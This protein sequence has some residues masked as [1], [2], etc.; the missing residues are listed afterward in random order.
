MKRLVA[1]KKQDGS[2]AY[3]ASEESGDMKVTYNGF[4]FTLRVP[5]G[6]EPPNETWKS[7]ALH[8]RYVSYFKV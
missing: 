1:D 4:M 6:A 2:L 8:S 5:A 3:T 7:L